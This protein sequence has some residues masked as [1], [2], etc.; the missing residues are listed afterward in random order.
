MQGSAALDNFKGYVA[1]SR[2]KLP[3]H[4]WNVSRVVDVDYGGILADRRPPEEEVLRALE[5]AELKTFA[6]GAD[7]SIT[8]RRLQADLEAQQAIVATRPPDRRRD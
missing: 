2:S 4:T 8:E 7:P 6:A 5:R 1:Q 3:T